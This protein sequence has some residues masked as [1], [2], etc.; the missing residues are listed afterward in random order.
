MRRREFITL[1]GAAPAW[2]FVARG[3]SYFLRGATAISF[4]IRLR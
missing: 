1:L 4:V 3:I 2:P